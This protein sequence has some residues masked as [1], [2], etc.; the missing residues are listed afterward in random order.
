MAKA[1]E[2]SINLLNTIRCPKVLRL[3]QHKLPEAKSPGKAGSDLVHR[4]QPLLGKALSQEK[5][6]S[7]RE[8][9]K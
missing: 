6:F 4:P 1:E 7:W 9:E 3:I 8:G 2:G 5:V